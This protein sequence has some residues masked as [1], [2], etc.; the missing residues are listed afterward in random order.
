VEVRARGTA[1]AR[2]GG[3]A[4]IDATGRY[5]VRGLIPAAYEVRAVSRDLRDRMPGPW[6][7]LTLTRSTTLD[8]DAGPAPG[9]WRG[10][11]VSGAAPVPK[12][13]LQVV[14]DAGRRTP[15]PTSA[16][17][18][19]VQVDIMGPGTYRYRALDDFL[20]AAPVVDGPW[21]FGPPTGTFT[22]REGSLTDVGD[23]AL[24]VH[25]R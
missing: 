5:V 7:R 2:Y 17:D 4:H 23:A 12:V 21:W 25:A 14:D 22:I 24:H 11:F 13:N 8:L 9:R 10:R 3:S 20:I 15:F 6:H 16:A 1:L 18:G 19:R